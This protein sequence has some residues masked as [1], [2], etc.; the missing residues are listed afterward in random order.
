M[1]ALFIYVVSRAPGLLVCQ[2]T[3]PSSRAAPSRA[4]PC[5]VALRG[6]GQHRMGRHRLVAA[7]VL[8]ILT[9]GLVVMN[10]NTASLPTAPVPAS[11]SAPPG[12]ASGVLGSSVRLA[13][14]LSLPATAEMHH[15]PYATSAFA[16]S[17]APV[18]AL[19]LARTTPASSDACGGDFAVAS[20]SKTPTRTPCLP[21][22]LL[23]QRCGV[24]SIYLA[25]LCSCL[26]ALLPFA[27]LALSAFASAPVPA[28]SATP[29][30]HKCAVKASPPCEKPSHIVRTTL[31]GLFGLC[32]TSTS[33]TT[34]TASLGTR[35]ALPLQLHVLAALLAW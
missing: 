17:S 20:D 4:A 25:W 3:A 30:T 18:P 34:T 32:C 14:S 8:T 1:R 12:A 21:R 27:R 26:V 5:R 16:S 11:A 6:P 35:T 29:S 13:D 7:L 23:L 2:F 9:V 22:L 10:L 33:T 31:W 15:H 24:S 19:A 28:C